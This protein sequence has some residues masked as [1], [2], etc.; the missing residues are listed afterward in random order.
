MTDFRNVPGLPRGLAN[1]NPGNIR[2]SNIAWLGKVPIA[3][4]TDGAFEQFVS[5]EDGVRAM[6]ENIYN[7]LQQGAG[8]ITDLINTYAPPGDGNDTS[9][10]IAQVAAA[11][12]LDPN[13]PVDLTAANLQAIV[14]AQM[15]V[16]NGAAAVA[17]NVS[18]ALIQAGL[19]LMNSNILTDIGNFITNNPGMSGAVVV[20]FFFWPFI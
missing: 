14:T 16:E 4:N 20:A 18:S 8:T 1:N 12:G 3:Q 13:T 5:F 2:I 7:I 6:G 10:Y 9:S 17:A 11:T 15:N 19:E